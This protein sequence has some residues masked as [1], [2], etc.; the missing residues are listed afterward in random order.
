M[1]ETRRAREPVIVGIRPEHGHLW[2]DELRLLRIDPTAGRMLPAEDQIRELD[3]A[4]F[5]WG[6]G[7]V[8]RHYRVLLPAR[9][10]GGRV[11]VRRRAG[12]SIG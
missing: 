4:L 1:S 9:P 6:G 10:F 2:D 12:V 7:A 11:P 5:G 3:E 8:R